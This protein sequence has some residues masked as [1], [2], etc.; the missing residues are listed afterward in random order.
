[1][2][3][4]HWELEMLSHK[5]GKHANH[6]YNLGIIVKRS[7][8]HELSWYCKPLNKWGDYF[9]FKG[10][11]MSNYCEVTS[12]RG[13]KRHLRKHPE[14][15]SAKYVELVSRIKGQGVRARWIPGKN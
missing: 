1:M 7:A 2:S 15:K 4:G 10:Y 5:N 6:R 11:L 13:F 8:E 9:S 12:L 3:K 14:L